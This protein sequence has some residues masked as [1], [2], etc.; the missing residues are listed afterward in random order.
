MNPQEI[1]NI[2][3][4]NDLTIIGVLVV[5]IFAFSIVI[6]NLFKI[7]QKLYNEHL[8]ELRTFNE[9]LQK[10]NNQYSESINIL[11]K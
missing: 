7:N 11:K 1:H 9:I 3:T 6:Y 4:W 10:I 8:S 5:F 2:A